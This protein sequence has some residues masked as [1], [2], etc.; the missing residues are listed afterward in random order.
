MSN[1]ANDLAQ[2]IWF[3]WQEAAGPGTAL[4]LRR[5]LEAGES[6]AK[7]DRVSEAFR[8][9]LGDWGLSW[10]TAAGW[11]AKMADHV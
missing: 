3:R 2:T 4:A 6:F 1:A 11:A 9:E 7:G 5:R 8:A 10:A